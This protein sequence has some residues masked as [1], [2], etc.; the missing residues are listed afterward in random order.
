MSIL[1]GAK[2]LEIFQMELYWGF[3]L[4]RRQYK[5]EAQVIELGARKKAPKK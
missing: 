4:Q 3:S 5:K 2:S 1:G